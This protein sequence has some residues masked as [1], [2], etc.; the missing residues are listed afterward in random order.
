M[1]VQQKLQLILKLSGLTQEQLAR[2][3]GVTFVALN[4]WINAKV[5]ATVFD[6]ILNAWNK[7]PAVFYPEGSLKRAELILF[8]I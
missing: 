7:K 3:T 6:H 1:T 2:K 5:K 4:R 8:D